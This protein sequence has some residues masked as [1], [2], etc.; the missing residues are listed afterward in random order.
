MNDRTLRKLLE[1]VASGSVAPETAARNLVDLPFSDLGYAKLD[2]HRELRHGLPEVVFGQ[3]KEPHQIAA[4]AAALQEKGQNLL[5]TRADLAAFEAVLEQVQTAEF[6]ATAKTITAQ[7]S[8]PLQLPGNLLIAAAGTSD[9]FVAEE[10]RV[11]AAAFGL[12]TELLCDVGVAGIHR[13]FRHQKELKQAAV[14]IVVAGMDGALPS[15]LA[16]LVGTPII[17]VPTSVGYGASFGGI[18][19]L[20]AMLNSCAAGVTVTNIDNGFG[21]AFA[22]Y[23]ILRGA[24]KDGTAPRTGPQPPPSG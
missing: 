22:A 1:Q 15:V 16:G 11:C 12:Q 6:N 24:K 9:L 3:G 7:A 4:I 14:V 2:H 5:V 18:A 17:A 19:A 20:L 10:A 13:L 23:R 8:P 21:A